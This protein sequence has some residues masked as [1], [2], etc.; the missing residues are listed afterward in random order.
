MVEEIKYHTYKRLVNM[1]LNLSLEENI[2]KKEVKKTLAI[3]VPDFLY[4]IICSESK[5]LEINR[6]DLCVY[7]ILKGLQAH[8]LEGGRSEVKILT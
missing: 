6:S 3:R 4:T 1:D 5:Y 8:S 7:F 2:K